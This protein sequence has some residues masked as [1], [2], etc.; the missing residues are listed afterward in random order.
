MLTKCAD[1]IDL[2]GKVHGQMKRCG[3]SREIRR[4]FTKAVRACETWEEAV[5]LTRKTL[6]KYLGGGT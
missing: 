5:Q 3:E 2:E 4:V 6:L 1:T